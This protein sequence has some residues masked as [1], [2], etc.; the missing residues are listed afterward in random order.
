M[1]TRI[2]FVSTICLLSMSLVELCQPVIAQ[3]AVYHSVYVGYNQ[4][5]QVQPSLSWESTSAKAQAVFLLGR[6]VPIYVSK[7][8]V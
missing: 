8:A 7:A 2:V 3:N 6:P 5:G 1:K 4:Q